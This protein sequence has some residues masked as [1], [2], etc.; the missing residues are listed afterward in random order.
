MAKTLFQIIIFMYVISK[1]P[2]QA[3]NCI[4]INNFQF[5]IMFFED[6]VNQNNS[7]DPDGSK[8][9]PYQN[10]SSAIN[11]N[12]DSF[13]DLTLILVANSMPY[14]FSQVQTTISL[15]LTLKYYY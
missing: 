11:Q 8:S 13:F 14:Y 6:Y 2:S 9:N 5:Y 15:N 12:S 10:I 4:A 7:I 3:S 1:Q